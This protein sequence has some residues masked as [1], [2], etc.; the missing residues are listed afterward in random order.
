MA[1]VDQGSVTHV[2]LLEPEGTFPLPLADDDGD[3]DDDVSFACCRIHARIGLNEEHPFQIE[4]EVPVA[5]GALLWIVY[6][7]EKAVSGGRT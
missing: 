1:K 4:S 2:Y 6:G 5:A 3:D 7:E